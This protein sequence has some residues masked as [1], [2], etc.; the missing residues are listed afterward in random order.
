VV[1]QVLEL[2]DKPTPLLLLLMP[3]LPLPLVEQVA[4]QVAEQALVWAVWELAQQALPHPPLLVLLA[5]LVAGILI[6]II[7]LITWLPAD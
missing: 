1:L 7:L 5:A 2:L 6:T 4:E 3:P